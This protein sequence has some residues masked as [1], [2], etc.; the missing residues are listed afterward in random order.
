MKKKQLEAMLQAAL[1]K[2]NEPSEFE[3]QYQKQLGEMDKIVES[4]DYRNL[5]TEYAPDFHEIE[6]EKKKRDQMAGLHKTGV[7]AWADKTGANLATINEFNTNAYLN[8]VR[9][10]NDQAVKNFI[11][12]RNQLRS[13]LMGA[14]V[15]RDKDYFNG[16]L[17]MLQGKQAQGSFWSDVGKMA[18]GTGLNLASKFI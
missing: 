16:I 10:T 14:Q 9:N 5:P 3:K 7:G 11:N 12:S 2:K 4:K 17:Q 1:A 8:D 13:G 6:I 18:I 15:D